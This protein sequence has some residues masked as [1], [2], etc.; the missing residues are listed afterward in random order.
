[1]KEATKKL[2]EEISNLQE[3]GLES[4]DVKLIQQKTRLATS[5]GLIKGCLMVKEMED[6]DKAGLI[7]NLEEVREILIKEVGNDE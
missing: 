2:Q 7:K 6:Y 5:L 3:E 1:M 4:F